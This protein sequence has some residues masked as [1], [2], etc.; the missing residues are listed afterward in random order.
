MPFY[1]HLLQAKNLEW[2]LVVA[3]LLVTVFQNLL[4]KL[5]LRFSY[6]DRSNGALLKRRLKLLL[7]YLTLIYTLS[8][9]NYFTMAVELI[10]LVR[11]FTTF[12]LIFPV[13]CVFANV[14]I[15]FI[16]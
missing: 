15:K 3:L 12:L 6:S 5:I 13:I 14:F 10:R 7:F 2:T 4:Y 16:F 1:R 11:S 9:I 8:K